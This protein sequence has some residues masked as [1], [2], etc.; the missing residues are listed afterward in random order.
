MR[1]K[2]GGSPDAGGNWMDTYGDMV[3]LLLTFFVMLYAMSNINEQKWQIFVKSINPNVDQQQ[4]EVAINQEGSGE[5]DVTGSME[6]P[7]APP[8]NVDIDKLYLTFSEKMDELGISGVTASRGED[9]T[10]I[11]FA[12]EAFF[13]GDSSD[14]TQKGQQALDVFCE[15]IA[16]QSGNIQQINIMGH[17]AQG[18]PNK[19]N[20]PR[21][22]R[23]LSAMRAAEV[24]I[25]IQGKNVI[26][27]EKLVSISYGQFRPVDTSETREGRAKNRRVELLLI[28]AG[29]DM[30]S[31]NEYYED[32]ISGNNEDK[33]IVTDGVAKEAFETTG[34][35]PEGAASAVP[36]SGVN[37]P[38][39]ADGTG[40]SD[41]GVLDEPEAE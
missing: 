24:S 9:Y 18:D 31:L 40:I 34:A 32:Y 33:T 23:M 22:D 19:P 30:K 25:Y 13:N 5:N 16:T 27:P 6:I 38:E 11:S 37:S 21:T 15:V 28:D 39:S 3:T 4:Q 10:F 8:E 35:I 14:L 29:V 26:E 36:S 7:D 1:K 12:N 2:K 17:T 41:G 20:N